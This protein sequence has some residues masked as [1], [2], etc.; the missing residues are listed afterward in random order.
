MD[1]LR[2]HCPECK[3]YKGGSAHNSTCVQD[4]VGDYVNFEEGLD[5]V[6]CCDYFELK[7][8]DGIIFFDSSC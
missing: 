8:N 2:H 6:M 3:F 7:E 1:E 4:N 5:S